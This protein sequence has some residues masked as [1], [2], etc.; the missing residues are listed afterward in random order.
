ME[1]ISQL[2]TEGAHCRRAIQFFCLQS[3]L[4]KCLNSLVTFDGC[5]IDV[6]FPWLG[7]GGASP[8]TQF[9]N[10][11]PIVVFVSLYTPLY[12]P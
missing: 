4:R 2:I 8:T 10:D 9:V 1:F 11:D 7:N 3:L 12:P 6:L 5:R